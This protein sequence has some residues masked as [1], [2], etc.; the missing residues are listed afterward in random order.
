ME[1]NHPQDSMSAHDPPPEDTSFRPKKRERKEEDLTPK[2]EEEPSEVKEEPGE[3]SP[4]IRSLDPMH[5]T[6]WFERDPNSGPG[7]APWTWAMSDQGRSNII[8]LSAK[9]RTAG[10][11]ALPDLKELRE[12]HEEL[13]TRVSSVEEC[14]TVH[15][16]REYTHR[17]ITIEERIGGFSGCGVIGENIRQCR[18][19]LDQC[20]TRTYGT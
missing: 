8:F 9:D 3:D 16:V 13:S 4:G 17:I 11:E 2:S 20:L 6:I 18:V 5:N 10:V 19:M 1:Q 7:E 15:H 14:I 12:G